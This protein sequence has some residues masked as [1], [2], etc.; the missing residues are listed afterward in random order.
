MIKIIY[1]G[2]DKIKIQQEVLAAYDY[3]NKIFLIKTVDVTVFVAQN[4]KEFDKQ[5]GEKTA[6]WLVGNAVGKNR[7]N[8]LSPLAMKN[9]SSHSP[10]EF[11]PILKHEFT[12]LFLS[13]LSNGKVIPNWLNEGLAAYVAKQHQNDKDAIFI[14]DNFCEKLSSSR[15]WNNNVHYGAY[16]LSALF[17][18]F[19]IKKYSFKKIEKLISSLN[20]YYYHPDFQKIFLKVYDCELEIME[21]L[22]IKEINK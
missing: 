22:F 14:E 4:R 3:V 15:G 9:E 7:I 18:K 21:K 1:E 5:F 17:V 20:K 10:K 6:S 19:L 16:L 11:L 13:N 8:I 2:E 12:H